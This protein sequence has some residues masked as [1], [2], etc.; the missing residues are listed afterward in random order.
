MRRTLLALVAVLALSG[1]AHAN[2]LSDARRALSGQF[3]QHH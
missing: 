1:L 2:D 3:T